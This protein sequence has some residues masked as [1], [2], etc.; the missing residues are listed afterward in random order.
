LGCVSLQVER[1]PGLSR[2]TLNA[3]MSLYKKE[4]ERDYNIGRKG[5]MTTEAD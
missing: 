4:A 1:Y 5:N 2:R 3:I